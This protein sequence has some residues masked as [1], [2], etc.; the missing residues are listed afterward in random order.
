M[1]LNSSDVDPN[2]RL[3]NL[4]KNYH[5]LLPEVSTMSLEEMETSKAYSRFLA[6]SRALSEL[7]VNGIELADSEL[8]SKLLNGKTNYPKNEYEFLIHRIS[9]VFG[10]YLNRVDSP[11]IQETQYFSEEFV[12]KVMGNFES[13]SIVPNPDNKKIRL[14]LPHLAHDYKS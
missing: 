11:K 3:E 4:L 7:N 8:I 9:I 5:K 14:E 2:R 6:T 10:G 1:V 12:G 13:G